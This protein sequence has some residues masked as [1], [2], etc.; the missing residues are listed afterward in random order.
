MRRS[1]GAARRTWI[2]TSMREP[3]RLTVNRGNSSLIMRRT[4]GGGFSVR[5]F[6][7][8]ICEDRI[9]LL[10]AGGLAPEIAGEVDFRRTAERFWVLISATLLGGLKPTAG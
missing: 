6:D 9:A 7:E 1:N 8:L 3:S 4:N 5:S 10:K 2:F